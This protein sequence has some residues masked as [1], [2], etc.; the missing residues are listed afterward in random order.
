M[1]AVDAIAFH[2]IAAFPAGCP[3][4]DAESPPTATAWAWLT[5]VMAA[6][7]MAASV[8]PRTSARVSLDM[9][10]SNRSTGALRATD[11]LPPATARPPPSAARR[12]SASHQPRMGGLLPPLGDALLGQDL[13]Q[14]GMLVIHVVLPFLQLSCFP[15][16]QHWLPLASSGWSCGGPPES[17]MCL[18][19]ALGCSPSLV[20][21]PIRPPFPFGRSHAIIPARW[22][23]AWRARPSWAASRS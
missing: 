12:A 7:F 2:S 1:I 3:R 5:V 4:A 15:G 18:T 23:A 17:G 20:A 14:P 13:A 8:A 9:V 10:A 16:N 11:W 6:R 22:A 19:P 21:G